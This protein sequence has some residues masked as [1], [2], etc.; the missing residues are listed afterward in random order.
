MDMEDKRDKNSGNTF[1]KNSF[2]KL[3]HLTKMMTKS[4][5]NSRILRLKNF[6]IVLSGVVI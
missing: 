1:A 3:K 5:K 2:R 6:G 4:A